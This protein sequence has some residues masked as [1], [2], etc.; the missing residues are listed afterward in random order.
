ML[1]TYSEEIQGQ[2]CATCP[3]TQTTEDFWVPANVDPTEMALTLRGTLLAI[4]ELQITPSE[5]LEEL[6]LDRELPVSDDE[7][8]P[9]LDGV[10][11][12]MSAGG[13]L[14]EACFRKQV[15]AP[16]ALV[17]ES[18]QWPAMDNIAGIR[19]LRLILQADNTA[20]KTTLLLQLRDAVIDM[21]VRR[22]APAAVIEEFEAC[23][24]EQLIRLVHHILS[25]PAE[26]NDA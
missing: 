11:V 15:L 3:G 5:A 2:L 22:N 23:S 12:G 7:H 20:D 21:Q 16:C 8:Q 9:Y 4:R 19:T 10:T 17:E 26:D 24:D 18:V 13:K 14:L 1:V 25:L 6:S